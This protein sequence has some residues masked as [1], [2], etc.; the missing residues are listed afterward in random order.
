MIST[1]VIEQGSLREVDGVKIHFL[2]GVLSMLRNDILEMGSIVHV[3]ELD[4]ESKKKG[5]N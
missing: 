1:V 4:V 2:D 3:E 5:K